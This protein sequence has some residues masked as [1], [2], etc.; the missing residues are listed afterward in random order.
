VEGNGNC[1]KVAG[2]LIVDVKDGFLCHGLVT[3]QGEVEGIRFGHAW[4]ELNDT[5]IDVS[6]GKQ[7]V[8]SKKRYYRIG[9]IKETEVKRYNQHEALVKMLK[10]GNYGPWK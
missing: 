8:M 2:N 7:L 3:G 4:I 10:T 9:N 6:N 1:Y 5:V